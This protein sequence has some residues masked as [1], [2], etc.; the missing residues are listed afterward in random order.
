MSNCI[1]LT[2][3]ICVLQLSVCLFSIHLHP[4]STYPFNHPSTHPPICPPIHPSIHPYAYVLYSRTHHA[5]TVLTGSPTDCNRP[6]G[7]LHLTFV[8][9]S[10]IPSQHFLLYFTSRLQGPFSNFDAFQCTVG[11]G[12]EPCPFP[13][14]PCMN[15]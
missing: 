13:F 5:L 8:A 7:T 2:R 1:I 10:S 6:S 12:I 4:S 14:N 15:D 11:C 9:F 3:H